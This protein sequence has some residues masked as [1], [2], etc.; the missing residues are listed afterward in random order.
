MRIL[1]NENFPGEAVAAL[2]AAGHDV[3]WVRTDAPGI[4]DTLVLEWA[5]REERILITFDKD[6]S[7]LAFRSRFPAVSGIVLFQILAPS[8]TAV[9]GA[10]V[11]A[12]SSRA[13]WAGHFTVVEDRRIRM[14]PLPR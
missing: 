2:R 8:S 12:L 6:F 13:D 4:N 9:A 14:R 10:A 5:Q 3:V 1:A 11:A 7:E